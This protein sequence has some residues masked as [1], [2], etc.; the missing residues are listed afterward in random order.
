MLSFVILDYFPPRRLYRIFLKHLRESQI[1]YLGPLTGGWGGGGGACPG[2][3][4]S[5]LINAHVALS[6]IRNVIVPCHYPFRSHV[7]RH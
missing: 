5:N 7:A 3:A 6:N 1:Y 4:L 2:V